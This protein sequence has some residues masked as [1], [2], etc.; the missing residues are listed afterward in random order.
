MSINAVRPV[1]E[2]VGVNKRCLGHIIQV[3]VRCNPKMLLETA[4]C[5]C[6]CTNDC[7]GVGK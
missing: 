5:V 4:K 1:K 7:A 2:A 6:E 3:K